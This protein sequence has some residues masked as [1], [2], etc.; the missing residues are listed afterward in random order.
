MAEQQLELI[1]KTK[2]E[3]APAVVPPR[4]L[5][6]DLDNLMGAFD[7][8]KAVANVLAPVN[9][10]DFIMPLHAVS[11]RLIQID[12]RDKRG[13]VYAPLGGEDGERALTKTALDK[14]AAAA[15]ISW[16]YN[17]CGRTDDGSD[18]RYASYRAVGTI[19]DLDGSFRQVVANKAMDLRPGS[20]ACQRMVEA[21]QRKDKNAT[22]AN[23]RELRMAM[24]HILA[25]AESKAFNR[26]IRKALGIKQKYSVEELCKPFVVPKLVF[27]G[28]SEDPAL[29]E[30]VAQRIIDRA[31][32]AQ[33][34]LY[35]GTSSVQQARP[36][37]PPPEM[38]DD[39]DE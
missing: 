21:A 23:C 34:N 29:R 36:L 8:A 7:A 2:E 5:Y 9:R 15:G 13:D 27:T 26:A 37:P 12:P 10:L 38:G 20:A 35:G 14:V 31:F 24:E 4:G 25:H 22:E 30:V 11:L 1:D 32:S 3:Q 39:D 33:G 19:Q 18:P 17:A 6:R 28:D 16:D